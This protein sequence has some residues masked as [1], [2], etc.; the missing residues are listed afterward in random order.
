MVG[1]RF[2]NRE[3][4]M[5]FFEDPSAAS[6]GIFLK[7][8]GRKVKNQDANNAWCRG[9]T[10]LLTG[11]TSGIGRELGRE[12]CARGVKRI[13]LLSR[14]TGRGR[15]QALEWTK[16]Y[17]G[18]EVDVIQVDFASMQETA[19]G[20]EQ[21]IALMADSEELIDAMVLCAATIGNPGTKR[22]FEEC[23]VWLWLL[24][25]IIPCLH[26]CRTIIFSLKDSMMR[27]GCGPVLHH[28]CI[29]FGPSRMTHFFL[30]RFKDPMLLCRE[31]DCGLILHHVCR[32]GSALVEPLIFFF[33]RFQYPMYGL[34][35][36]FEVYAWFVQPEPSVIPPFAT[37]ITG[38]VRFR[39]CMK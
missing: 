28:V 14:D 6:P 9:G 24:S 2:L 25:D 13:V 20:M 34:R 31:R 21:V 30:Q 3:A 26:I 29:W 33:L 37:C 7:A 38:S 10:V 36:D 23:V 8:L 16:H 39:V 4:A 18:V 27:T 22:E 5:S 1:E 19:R 11:G 35:F 12:L 17:K 15:L 32:Y